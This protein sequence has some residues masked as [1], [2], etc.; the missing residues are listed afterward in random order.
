MCPLF[1]RAAMS[2]VAPLNEAIREFGLLT[3]AFDSNWVP[4]KMRLKNLV[5]KAVET[6][7]YECRTGTSQ[8]SCTNWRLSQ[9]D[10]RLGNV[11]RNMN[12]HLK[13]RQLI[14]AEDTII[15]G[16]LSGSWPLNGPYDTLCPPNHAAKLFIDA[17]LFEIEK[18]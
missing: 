2:I 15:H 13:T 9:I 8:T 17:M 10:S 7:F 6:D 5:N 18:I 12:E 1:T 3:G 16:A 14:M 4:K 11:G